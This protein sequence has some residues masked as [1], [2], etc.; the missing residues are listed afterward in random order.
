MTC[1]RRR[2][3]AP[4]IA[5]V[6]D[7][8]IG[9]DDPAAAAALAEDV[10]AVG[11]VLTVVT[12]DSTMRARPRQFR[13]ARRLLARLPGPLLVVAGNHDLPLAHP[14]RLIDPLARYRRWITPE[15]DPVVRV[16]GVV[17]L[18]L[19]SMPRWRWKSGRVSRRQAAEV[20]RVLG[21]A[22]E[23]SLR[24][25]ALHHPPFGPGSA[26]L[27][28]RRG[29]REALD[30]AR[31]DVIL[32]GHTHVPDVRVYELGGGHRV[33]V[34]VAGTA[35]SR[36]TRGFAPSWSAIEA[37]ADHVIVRERCWGERGWRAGRTVRTPRR[38]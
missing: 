8:H 3:P 9:A 26:G 12:G 23:G 35:T 18:G 14:Q 6:S 30:R 19:M 28:G 17:A 13:R 27:L 16:P 10:A 36:R 1:G 33:T 29:L 21:G 5:H 22:P 34:V 20:V 2:E 11:P 25:L 4:L 31:V 7:L 24:L 38:A 32:A 15:L 37:T